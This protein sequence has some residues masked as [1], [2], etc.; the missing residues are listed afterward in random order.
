MEYDA[1]KDD[2]DDDDNDD[3][4]QIGKGEGITFPTTSFRLL[5][6]LP[7]YGNL[8]TERIPRISH[9]TETR[10]LFSTSTGGW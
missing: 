3:D 5:L 9:C 8:A 6:L 7:A 1:G 2:G 4:K 10:T